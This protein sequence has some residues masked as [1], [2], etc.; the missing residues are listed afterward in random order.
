MH[1]PEEFT[2]GPIGLSEDC[3]CAKG[4]EDEWATVLG[5]PAVP[6]SQVSPIPVRRWQ[7]TIL[8]MGSPASDEEYI[9]A[10]I[11]LTADAPEVLIEPHTRKSK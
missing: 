1:F 6:A 10:Y 9:P 3:T 7:F 2:M 5:L 8:D 4:M 11:G